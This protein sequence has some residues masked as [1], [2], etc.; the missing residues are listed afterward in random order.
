MVIDIRKTESG[1]VVS[2]DDLGNIFN[3]QATI[4]ADSASSFAGSTDIDLRYNAYI[5]DQAGLISGDDSVYG[6]NTIA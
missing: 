4:T 5:T 1:V 2:I 6:T 3:S